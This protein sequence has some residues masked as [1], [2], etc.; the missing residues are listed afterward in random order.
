[1]ALLHV[2]DPIL[3]CHGA[4]GIAERRLEDVEYRVDV[5]KSN[6]AFDDTIRNLI[7]GFGCKACDNVA[8]PLLLGMPPVTIHPKL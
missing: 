5:Y 3:C 7:V 6:D 8:H 2:E 4:I 1:M